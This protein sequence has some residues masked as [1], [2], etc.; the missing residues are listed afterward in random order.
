MQ[1]AAAVNQYPTTT[2]TTQQGSNGM[3]VAGLVMGILALVL[4]WVPFVNWTLAILGVIFGGVGLAKSKRVGKG[5]G[6]AITGLTLSIV[7]IIASVVLYYM[8]VQAAKSEIE[9]ELRNNPALLNE[10]SK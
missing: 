9:L 3:A 6:M 7:S 1:S 2:T 4:C 10:L 5:K 8:A